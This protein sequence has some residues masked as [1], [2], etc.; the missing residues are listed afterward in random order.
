VPPVL[1]ARLQ[2]LIEPADEPRHD[3]DLLVVFEQ[4]MTFVRV[5]DA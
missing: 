4:E 1:A 3:V 5:D 2:V